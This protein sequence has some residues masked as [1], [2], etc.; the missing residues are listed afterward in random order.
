MKQQLA[1][2]AILTV[3]STSAVADWIPVAIHD[4]PGSFTV[5][6]D[7]ATIRRSGHLV[8]IWELNNYTVPQV[9]ATGASF[10][11][12]EAQA[13]YDCIEQRANILFQAQFSQAMGA[14]NLVSRRSNPAGWFPVPP[15]SIA[16]IMLKFACRNR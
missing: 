2:A 4:E 7:P 8:T 10:L 11:S 6:A 5:Y 16:E 14:G 13:E 12:G 9:I 1:L 15:G 3:L